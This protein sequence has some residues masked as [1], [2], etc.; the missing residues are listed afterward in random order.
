M[1]PVAAAR[2]RPQSLL[3]R[4]GAVA[5]LSLALGIL[6][7]DR[8]AELE[9]ALAGH[10]A[11][12]TRGIAALRMR[13][14]ATMGRFNSHP[15]PPTDSG[16]YA[17][18]A[19]ARAIVLSTNQSLS[20]LDNA[21]TQAAQRVEAAIRRDTGAAERVLEEGNAEIHRAIAR[22]AERSATTERQIAALETGA[23]ASESKG[24]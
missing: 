13:H 23:M 7:C 17:R 3:R 6:G 15:T 5:V 19:R 9:A 11:D 4:S 12:W 8:A 1:T 2:R 24:E 10:R 18:Q 21:A 16:S 20:D 22:M 14:G